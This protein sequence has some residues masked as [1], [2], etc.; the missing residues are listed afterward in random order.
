MSDTTSPHPNQ[1]RRNCLNFLQ[2]YELARWLR[3]HLDWCK[4]QSFTGQEMVDRAGKELSFPITVANARNLW[5]ELGNEWPFTLRGRNGNG[6]ASNADRQRVLARS[7]LDL[8]TLVGSDID[9]CNRDLLTMAG[10]ASPD[11]E[12]PDADQG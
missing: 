6:K 2:K 5:K 3:K 8:Y 12:V 7:I 11:K 4:K 1:R 10:V 9:E